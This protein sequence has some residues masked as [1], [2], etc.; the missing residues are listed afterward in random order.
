MLMLIHTY[1][2][3]CVHQPGSPLNPTHTFGIFMEASSCRHDPLSAQ[4]PA[5]FPFEEDWAG[6]AKSFIL[7]TM[8]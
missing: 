4:F 2:C 3:E 7:L 1:A 5:F 8:A 6:K